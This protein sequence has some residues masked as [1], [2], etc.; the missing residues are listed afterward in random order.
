MH[1]KHIVFGLAGSLYPIFLTSIVDNPKI[2]VRGTTQNNESYCG[3]Q[4]EQPIIA[5]T[6]TVEKNIQN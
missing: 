5:E 2:S 4:I 6:Q 3:G 1:I